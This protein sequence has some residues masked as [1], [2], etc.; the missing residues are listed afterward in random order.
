M[1]V[2]DNGIGFD[3]GKARSTAHG[4]IGIKERLAAVGGKFKIKSGRTE[5]L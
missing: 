3:K 5:P 1:L 4:L 2:S